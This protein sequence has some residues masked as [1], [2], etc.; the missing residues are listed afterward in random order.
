MDE[1]AAILRADLAIRS[2]PG[3]GTIVTL[4]IPAATPGRARRTRA[5]ALADANSTV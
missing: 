3:H 1:R 4:T 2:T 5:T